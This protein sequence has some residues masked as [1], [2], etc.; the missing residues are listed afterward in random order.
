[1]SLGSLLVCHAKGFA[2]LSEQ[3]ALVLE[4][5]DPSGLADSLLL[6]LFA[7]GFPGIVE[8]VPFVLKVNSC[9]VEEETV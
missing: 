8:W 1:M 5:G 6:Q 4:Y 9:V 3:N 7:G 2:H